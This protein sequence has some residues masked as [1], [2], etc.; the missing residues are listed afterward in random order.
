MFSWNWVTFTSLE[1]RFIDI[2]FR[3]GAGKASWSVPTLSIVAQQSVYCTFINVWKRNQDKKLGQGTN[4]INLEQ[5][6]IL[7]PYLFTICQGI[8]FHSPHLIPLTI[9]KGIH[10]ILCICITSWQRSGPQDQDKGH[11]AVYY[12]IKIPPYYSL[13]GS[14]L[15]T[16]IMLFIYF[17]GAWV[18]PNAEFKYVDLQSQIHV[19]L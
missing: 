8:F 12:A 2:S 16:R 18:W 14:Q 19:I 1:I 6:I 15:N 5:N 13:E 3:T 17:F 11:Y 4:S 7:S 10:I 9:Q